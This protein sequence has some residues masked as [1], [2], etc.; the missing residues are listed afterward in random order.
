MYTDAR[1][2]NAWPRSANDVMTLVT[3]MVVER[4]TV[5]MI[6]IEMINSG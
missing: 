4:V 5:T 2:K 1:K 6:V 3:V